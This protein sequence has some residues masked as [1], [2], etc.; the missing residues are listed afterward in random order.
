M[1]IGDKKALDDYRNQLLGRAQAIQRHLDEVTRAAREEL[2]SIRDQ[3]RALDSPQKPSEKNGKH[4]PSI[5]ER[6]SVTVA[7]TV[8]TVLIVEKRPSYTQSLAN[9]IRSAGFNPVI[10][11]TAEGGL[12]K[13]EQCRPDLIL[14]EIELPDRD[15]L[16]FVSEIRRQRENRT[17]IIAMS[18]LPHLKPRCLELGCNDF[19]LKPIRMI[20]LI[21]RLRKF[22]Y[23]NPEVS[24]GNS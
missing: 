17:P 5:L 8:K 10:A 12:R 2:V 16:R 7:K 24:N 21:R 14:L 3:I 1:S 9:Q 22:L 18:A 4:R 6:K 20:D 13:A 11:V 15:G 19:L 23:Y